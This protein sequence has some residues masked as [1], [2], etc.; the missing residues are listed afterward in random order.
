MPVLGVRDRRINCLGHWFAT[1]YR[2]CGRH[3]CVCSTVPKLTALRLDESSLDKTTP[4]TL[5]I[6]QQSI[7]HLELDSDSVNAAPQ[8]WLFQF[9]RLFD[10]VQQLRLVGMEAIIDDAV[11]AKSQHLHVQRLNIRQS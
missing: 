3:P 9:L 1:S 10:Q 4:R 6:R 5:P 2:F 7:I 8:T 11:A